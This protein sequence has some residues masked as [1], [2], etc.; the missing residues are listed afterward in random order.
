M[1]SLQE[2]S[3]LDGKIRTNLLNKGNMINVANEVSRKIK[4]KLLR[5]EIEGLIHYMKE[6]DYRSFGSMD[7][8]FIINKIASNFTY[9]LK[10]TE[11]I[12]IDTREILKH[13]IGAVETDNYE[14]VY[15]TVKCAPE[16]VS[17][18]ENRNIYRIDKDKNADED[19]DE[20]VF[21]KNMDDNP[22]YNFYKKQVSER[23]T[24]MFYNG[25]NYKK[26]HFDAQDRDKLKEFK[27]P[28]SGSGYKFPGIK[29][30]N[31]QNVYLLLDSKF[32]N[33][34]TSYDVFQWTVVNSANVTQGSVNTLCDK[35]SNIIN[36]QFEKFQMPYNP[37]ADNV[38]KKISLFIDEFKSMSVLINSGRRYHMLFNSEVNGNQIELTPL[39]ND[40]GKFRFHT[41]INFLDTITMTFQSP[42]S[43][44]EFSKDRYNIKITVLNPT[45]ALL[46]FSEDHGVVDGEL[47][48]IEEFNTLN[49]NKDDKQIRE[50]NRE[51]GHI[52]TFLSNTELTIEYNLTTATLDPGNISKCFIASRR[53]IVPIR[54]EYL[55]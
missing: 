33:L 24:Q 25:A 29:K 11:G 4:R 46:T 48:H 31:I 9:Q 50:I 34:S 27:I 16:S 22:E 32:R 41:P 1:I 54:M 52:V 51:Q 49:P 17:N 23:P 55:V 45:Q 2:N 47:V 39:T 15:S 36:I 28:I 40:D 7:I 5:S 19:E 38:Y 35:I 53:L 8:K 26:E 13:H 14:S 42:F 43:P 3:R 6:I 37:S 18:I 30:Q 12:F 10:N 44:V 21:E 20:E